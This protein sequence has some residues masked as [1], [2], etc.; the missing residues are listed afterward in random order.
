MSARSYLGSELDELVVI[1]AHLGPRFDP[2]APVLGLALAVAARLDKHVGVPA[3]LDRRHR[4]CVDRDLDAG[5]GRGRGEMGGG[6]S[7]VES[8][9]KSR[10]VGH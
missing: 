8:K 6:P 1:T 4:D 7:P 5:G 3:V 9:P 2:R 10:D